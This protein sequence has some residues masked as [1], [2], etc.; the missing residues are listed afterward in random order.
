MIMKLTKFATALVA[1]TACLVPLVPAYAGPGP[2]DLYGGSILDPNSSALSS[3]PRL[4]CDDIVQA[5]TSERGSQ[6][7]RDSLEHDKSS[8]AH[9]NMNS[10]S[11]SSSE[12]DSKGASFIG[13]GAK[14]SNEET[15]SN[16]QATSDEGKSDNSNLSQSKSNDGSYEKISTPTAAGKACSGLVKA[17]GERDA[18]AFNADAEVKKVDIATKGKLEAIKSEANS[19][20]LESLMKW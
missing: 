8:N 11:S 13:I 2:L 17:A 14:T 3:D 18:A 10:S 9:K 12:K 15:S 5:A 19:K 6:T 4:L 1:A 20:F 16:Q 7:A